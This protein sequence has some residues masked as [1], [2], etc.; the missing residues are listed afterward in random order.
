MARSSMSSSPNLRSG[1]GEAVRTET[2]PQAT[3][4]A[5]INTRPPGEVL[6]D[7]ARGKHDAEA[8]AAA[9]CGVTLDGYRRSRVGPSGTRTADADG[10]HPPVPRELVAEQPPDRDRQPG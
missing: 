8:G 5:R 9:R 7:I 1:T 2:A 10:F 3:G 4:T 6:A